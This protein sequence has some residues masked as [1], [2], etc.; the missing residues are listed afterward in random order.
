M[1]DLIASPF[2]EGHV[3][4]RPGRHEG[5]RLGVGRY[6]ELLDA[7]PQATV[8]GW[9]VKAAR[10][11]WGVALDGRQL[12]GTV[13]VRQPTAL[14]YGRASWEINKGCDYDCEHCYL[15][16]K[17]FEGLAWDDK[18]KMLN[19]VRDSGALW[20]QITGGEPLI[21]RDF[22]A[23]YQYANELGLMVS[24]ASNG[25]QLSKPRIQEI[26]ARHRPYLIA[27]SVYGATAA[28]YDGMT[29]NRGAF[30]RFIKGLEVSR[31]A[32]LPLKLNIVVSERNA[33]EIAQMRALAD[34]YGFPHHVFTTM[35]P[36]IEGGGERMGSQAADYVMPRKPFQGC[37]AGHTFFHADPWG[38][39]S[40]CKVG[41]DP[42]F[43]LI[44]DGVDGLRQL[45][46]VADSL[47]LRTGGCSGCALSG[48]CFT[49]RPL[50][51]LYQEAK[52][53]LNT[54]CQ[55]GGR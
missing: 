52:A 22:P 10:S 39:A 6:R 16:L 35:S 8:P 27:V 38:K 51:K 41:R 19:A 24:I 55:H 3:A 11:A 20:F 5:L 21:D 37:N 1:H 49:C 30:D 31:D 36:T 46:A 17:N 32:G 26:F 4:V 43:D 18:V 47:Q 28:S 29:R 34:R 45:G 54:Y 7:P 33:G 44:T 14:G 13:L 2:L 25:S 12:D 15:G 53:P 50:A 48:T 23:S 42:Q 9:L 40:I